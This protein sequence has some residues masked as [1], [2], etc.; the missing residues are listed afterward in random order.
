MIPDS[1]YGIIIN[2]N[3]YDI[4]FTIV[5]VYEMVKMK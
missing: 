4:E 3:I 2:T 5:K 1:L